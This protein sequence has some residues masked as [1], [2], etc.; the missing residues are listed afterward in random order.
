MLLEYVLAEPRSFCL[1]ITRNGATVV[2]LPAGRKRIEDLVDN[3]LNAIRS[4]QSENT[5]GTELFSILLQPV[6]DDRS[7]RLTV[8]PD[9]KLHLLPFDA[10]KD[11][12]GRYILESHIVTYAP[13]ATT[14]HI[15][16]TAP[17]SDQLTATFLGV[18]DVPYSGPPV[19]RA[20][21]G[22]NT[23]SDFFDVAKLPSLPGTKEEVIG[24]S[25]IVK[26]S[27][28]LLLGSKATEAAFKSIPLESFRMIHL[29]VHGLADTQFPDRTALVLSS[30]SGED[31][32]L[33]VR[34]IR[35]LSLRA[36]LVVLSACDTG[37]GQL[38]GQEGIASLERAFL[39]AGAKAVVASLWTAE[40]TY[41]AAVMKRFY[42]YLADGCDKAMAL[43]QA[44]IDLLKDFGD[45]AL[46]VY[47]AGFTLVGVSTQ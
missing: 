4:R 15:L 35:N 45:Q 2:V 37:I 40:D 17:S 5:V 8:I 30:G 27:N 19:S 6:I 38:L 41:T 34:E 24:V 43:R 44:K 11:Q 47:W 12:Q 36:D 20:N 26:G 33:Q 29:A 16:R 3:Y 32:L 13:S 22:V 39:L 10:L 9:G 28:Q 31:G 1:R 23:I 7:S 21:V 46:P 14:L 25:N 42:S 18:G